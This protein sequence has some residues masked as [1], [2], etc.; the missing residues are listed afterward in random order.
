MLNDLWVFNADYI[1]KIFTSLVKLNLVE[2]FPMIWVKFAF[3]VVFLHRAFTIDEMLSILQY[4][5]E[6]SI[7]KKALFLHKR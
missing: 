1:I 5:D 2:E 3:A 6:V 4:L 7:I